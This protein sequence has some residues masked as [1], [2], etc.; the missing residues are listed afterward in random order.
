MPKHRL[1]VEP[2]AGSA[3]Y[4]L[5]HSEHEVWINELSPRI[6]RIWR[7]VQ[8]ATRKHIEQ[9][10][11]PTP[12]EDLRKYK[13]LSE[14]ERDLLGLSV[15]RGQAEPRNVLS[16]WAAESNEPWRLKLR[17]LERLEDIRDWRIT[18]LDYFDLPDLEG[19]WYVDP[20]YQFARRRYPE[21]D[22]DYDELGAWCRSRR[23]QVIVCEEL[24]ATWLPFKPLKEV[25]TS[26]RRMTEAVW[27]SET[28][29]GR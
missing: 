23:G 24:G 26:C 3:R 25:W 21:D 19:T 18:N 9:L 7:W 2:F 15:C 11:E 28:G 27:V 4:S 8:Q 13:W 12:G 10:P 20:P 14:V 29:G 17:L 1:I 5:H 6:Y 22:I 16:G